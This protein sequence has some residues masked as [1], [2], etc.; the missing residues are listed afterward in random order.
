MI[1]KE[2]KKP[3]ILYFFY[4][5]CHTKN[6]F[7]KIKTNSVKNSEEQNKRDIKRTNEWSKNPFNAIPQNLEKWFMVCENSP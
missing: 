7:E 4:F 3:V 1:T 5:D 6:Y 2:L